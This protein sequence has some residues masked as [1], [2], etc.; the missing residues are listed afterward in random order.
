MPQHRSHFSLAS[1]FLLVA[2]IALLLAATRSAVMQWKDKD[3]ALAW[4]AAGVIVG[5][6]TGTGIGLGTRRW[7]RGGLI[8]F[9]TGAMA[10]GMAGAQL[11]GPPEMFIVLIGV[12]TLILLSAVLRPKTTADV[13]DSQDSANIAFDSAENPRESSL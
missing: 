2:Y 8:G 4:V 9:V 11:G 3:V 1:L 13:L 6:V 10:G 12:V 7:F 5:A